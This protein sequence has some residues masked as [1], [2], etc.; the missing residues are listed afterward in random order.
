M[1]KMKMGAKLNRIENAF[2]KKA[3]IAYLTAGDCSNI[4][5]YFKALIKSGVNVLEVGIPF[6]DPVAD[7]PVI[8]M[9]MSRAILNQTNLV[10]VWSLIKEIRKFNNDVAIILFTYLNP[11]ISDMQI[12]INNAREAGVDGILVVDMPFEES[13]EF[14]NLCK[15]YDISSIAVT[16]PSTSLDRIKMLADNGSGFLY[17]ACR[18]GTTGIK[19]ELPADIVTRISEIKE[20][21][22]LPVAV[23]FGIS[24][25]TMVKEVLNQADGV[26]VG[27]FFVKAIADGK[28]PLELEQMAQ[29][30][31]HV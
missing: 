20:Y 24:N 9:A 7:G 25:N 14:R 31:F 26:V 22:S 29:E 15:L 10:K 8:Q 2:R 11:I 21:S 6:S 3:R 1:Q 28:T 17:Y 19:H 5:D 18:S 30:L 23:G 27:S 12:F 4:L 16:A 13:G